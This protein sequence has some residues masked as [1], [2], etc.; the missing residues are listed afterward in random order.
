MIKYQIFTDPTEVFGRSLRKRAYHSHSSS[1]KPANQHFSPQTQVAVGSLEVIEE[2]IL[3]QTRLCK[4]GPVY[5]WLH[6]SRVFCYDSKGRSYH[7][8]SAES[9]K[10]LP[11][12]LQPVELEGGD[13]LGQDEPD[14]IWTSLDNNLICINKGGKQFKLMIK[15]P[16]EFEPSLGVTNSGR[17]KTDSDNSYDDILDKEMATKGA[18]SISPRN[19]ILVTLMKGS[20]R[21][22]PIDP[23]ASYRL[24]K[25]CYPIGASLRRSELVLLPNSGQILVQRGR[26]DKCGILVKDAEYSP[27]HQFL[28][29][30]M[31]LD[32]SQK[33]PI[34]VTPKDL[35]TYTFGSVCFLE[36]E[37]VLVL[38]FTSSKSNV[39]QDQPKT[40]HMLI[41]ACKPTT[42]EVVWIKKIQTTAV[43]LE[44]FMDSLNQLVIL[45]TTR[46]FM[47][48]SLLELK[49]TFVPGKFS[50]GDFG[51]VLGSCLMIVRPT[52]LKIYSFGKIADWKHNEFLQKSIIDLDPLVDSDDG[53]T[54]ERQIEF[55]SRSITQTPIVRLSLN[56]RTVFIFQG[57]EAI[58]LY[59]PDRCSPKDCPPEDYEISI[60]PDD[61]MDLKKHKIEISDDGKWFSLLHSRE[62]KIYL[63]ETET[64]KKYFLMTLESK[65]QLPADFY[66]GIPGDFVLMKFSRV[67][68][69]SALLVMDYRNSRVVIFN[70]PNTT[71]PHIDD[72]F[73]I[74]YFELPP[75]IK[76]LNVSV[77]S[78]TLLMTGQFIRVSSH[79]PAVMVGLLKYPLMP[80]RN[81]CSYL[82]RTHLWKHHFRVEDSEGRK[83]AALKLVRLITKI[84]P[85][86]LISFPV[87]SAML[88]LMNQ[89]GLLSKYAQHINSEEMFRSPVLLKLFYSSVRKESMK[90]LMEVF[91]SFHS[92][93]KRFP[94][95][96]KGIF[97]N[98]I[99]RDSS[100]M[101]GDDLRTEFLTKLLFSPHWE[102][103]SGE[104]EDE[105]R[106]TLL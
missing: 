30:K 23:P 2:R 106:I 40:S 72:L 97:A 36:L 88:Y 83:L 74:G 79:S 33:S 53:N 43:L 48:L 18:V 28:Y 12:K 46:F 105:A 86:D 73:P 49:A 11:S 17:A 54:P 68:N 31:L 67:E 25:S 51:K 102:K 65:T 59:S 56:Q 94:R 62:N 98:L 71:D 10:S 6:Q 77:R 20:M 78:D 87:F 3:P 52:H 45:I 104:L 96:A 27:V 39:S 15:A 8:F 57:N 63:F 60:I 66:S 58:I 103:F 19:N 80:L 24:Q 35:D 93:H 90:E 22:Y 89:P 38:T 7:Q 9:N 44:H 91:D 42:G 4:F 69:A 81:L 64:L 82:I 34:G 16:M 95:L 99:V 13:A 37:N 55:R 100:V 32:A 76:I 41:M 85:Q 1:E 21:V 61:K 84:R 50:N 29:A 92:R 70:I 26:A 75:L 101:L 14:S 47:V 5:P